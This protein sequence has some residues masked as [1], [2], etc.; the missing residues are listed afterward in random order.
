MHFNRSI[1]G[2]IL[3]Q[4]AHSSRF[5]LHEAI[6]G[7][8]SGNW[9]VVVLAEVLLL[10]NELGFSFLRDSL[11]EVSQILPQSSLEDFTFKIL[12]HALLPLAFQKDGK[13]KQDH[14]EDEGR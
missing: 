4:F 12:Y 11:G 8:V 3:N 1:E 2:I 9:K 7:L 10:A 5:G 6:Q 13:S 14:K